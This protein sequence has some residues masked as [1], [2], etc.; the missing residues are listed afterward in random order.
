[1]FLLLAKPKILKVHFPIFIDFL[2]F[3]IQATVHKLSVNVPFHG[4]C[5]LSK[6]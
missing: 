4:M 6:V 1:M 2:V 3:V 5:F